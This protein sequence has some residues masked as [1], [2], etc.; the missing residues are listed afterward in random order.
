[1]LLESRILHLIQRE[2]RKNLILF[3]HTLRVTTPLISPY[4]K[5]TD[6]IESKA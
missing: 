6:T 5:Q 3:L 4:L 2:S 1:M